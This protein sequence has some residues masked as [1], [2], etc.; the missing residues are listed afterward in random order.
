MKLS[1][2]TVVAVLALAVTGCAPPEGYPA[3]QVVR[4]AQV[5][6]YGREAEWMN[7]VIPRLSTLAEGG[8]RLAQANLGAIYYVRQDH[9]KAAKWV[10]IAAERGDP[11]SQYYFGFMHRDGLGGVPKDVVHAYKW[12]ILS[13]EGVTGERWPNP[14]DTWDPLWNRTLAK[15]NEQ[16]RTSLLA[17]VEVAREALSTELSDAERAEAEKFALAWKMFP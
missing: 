11:N 17:E 6:Y 9:T 2:S 3:E 7:Y 1:I 4:T 5:E 10:G 15:A 14:K 16:K 12:F 8:D 13:A